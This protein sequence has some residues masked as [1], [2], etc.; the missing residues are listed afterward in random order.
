MHTIIHR[1]KYMGRVAHGCWVSERMSFWQTIHNTEK[2]ERVYEY[3][4]LQ[5]PA[6]KPAQGN[7]TTQAEHNIHT[8]N[9]SSLGEATR[10]NPEE[11]GEGGTEGAQQNQRTR[12][13]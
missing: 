4:P 7:S 10:P 8:H 3:Q 11:E 6:T 2:A 1:I 13:Q 12:E 9:H 5:K